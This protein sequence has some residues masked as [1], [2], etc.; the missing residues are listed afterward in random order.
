MLAVLISGKYIKEYAMSTQAQL[1]QADLAL[2]RADQELLDARSALNRAQRI[3]ARAQE[4]GSDVD[5]GLLRQAQDGVNQASARVTQANNAYTA[6]QQNYTTVFNQPDTDAAE[7]PQVNNNAPAPPPPPPPAPTTSPASQNNPPDPTLG[8]DTNEQ[9]VPLSEVNRGS[10]LTVSDTA[11][12]DTTSDIPLASLQTSPND[13]VFD[14][15]GEILPADSVVAQQIAFQQREDDAEYNRVVNVAPSPLGGNFTAVYDPETGK[16]NVENLDNGE[17]VQTGLT[18]AQATRLA[19]ELSEGDPAYFSQADDEDTNIN[20]DLEELNAYTAEASQA[21]TLLAQ[22]RQQAEVSE[23]RKANGKAVGDGDWR[24]RLRLAPYATYLYKSPEGAGIM[25]PLR[26][27]DGVVFPYTPRIDMSYVADYNPT[28]LV[29]S[30]YRGYFYKGSRVG[31][32]TLT[33]DFTAQDSAEAD[34]L[35][36]TIHFFRS[37]TKMFYGQDDERGA[38]PPLVFLTG[39]GEFQFNEHPCVIQQFNYNLPNDV[40]YI[41]A[42]GRQSTSAGV[43]Q[44][45]NGLLYRRQ[46]TGGPT[47]SYSLSNIW[48]RLTGANVPL[49]AI[50]YPPAPP[51]LGLNSPTYVPTKM[52]VIL[53]LLPMPTRSQVT[54]QFSLDRYA[55][56][57]LLKGGFW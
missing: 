14:A 1:N 53:T 45:G 25:E 49:G 32:V 2:Q 12:D 16:F 48:S 34:Y 31:E 57:N 15:N 28:D 20:T 43:T 3:L 6:A 4:A 13:F 35:L 21:Q 9:V 10:F 44:G 26:N 19:A 47:N 30:N 17:T 7:N 8:L 38:P 54:Q 56:G 24:V 51:N 42:R 52:Q 50:N 29:H 23:I 36:A 40:D 22:A 5:P 18:D 27:T 55:N 46:Q 37:C 41:R 11:N 39:L 33:A